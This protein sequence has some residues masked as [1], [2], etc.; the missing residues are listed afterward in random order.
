MDGSQHI[1]GGLVPRKN[2]AALRCIVMAN[3]ERAGVN[4]CPETSTPVDSDPAHVMLFDVVVPLVELEKTRIEH[5]CTAVHLL[6][7]VAPPEPAAH[8]REWKEVQPL[9]LCG[10]GPLVVDLPRDTR[11]GQ[12]LWRNAEVNI[13]IAP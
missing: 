1:L 5:V 6:K 8:Q 9:K 4:G 10:R 12:P 11:E 7:F 2:E 13:V 3:R